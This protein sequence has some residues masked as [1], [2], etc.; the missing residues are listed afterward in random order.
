MAEIVVEK[1]TYAPYEFISFEIAVFENNQAKISY[2]WYDIVDTPI[3]EINKEL[4]RGI[5]NLIKLSN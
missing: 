5:N 3:N 1:A 4:D 2:S